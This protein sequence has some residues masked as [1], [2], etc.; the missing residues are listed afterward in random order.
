MDGGNG[1]GNGR[2]KGKDMTTTFVKYSQFL[3][4]IFDEIFGMKHGDA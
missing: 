2:G 3:N 4:E 1:N